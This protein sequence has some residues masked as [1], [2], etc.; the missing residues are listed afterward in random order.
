M[1]DI[2]LLCSTFFILSFDSI[3]P[4]VMVNVICIGP[5]RERTAARLEQQQSPF[6]QS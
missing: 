5:L 6:M 3:P 1:K 2:Y 4:P